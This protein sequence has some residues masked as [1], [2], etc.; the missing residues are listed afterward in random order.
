MLATKPPRELVLLMAVGLA[1]LISTAVLYSLG[2]IAELNPLMRPLLETSPLLF[3]GVKLL[4]LAIAY[5]ALQHYRKTDEGFV[6]RSSLYGTFAY[7]GIW[8]VWASVGR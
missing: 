5:A 6:R 7:V 2:L 3:C 8:V 1:D 4:T